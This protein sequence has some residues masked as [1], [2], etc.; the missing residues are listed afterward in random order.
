MKAK[1]YTILLFCIFVAACAQQSGTI[2]N[3]GQNASPEPGKVVEKTCTDGIKN[4]KES[5]VDCGG[6]CKKCEAGK[7]C[8]SNKDCV[9]GF[10]LN[11][12][13]AAP[14]CQD[15][16]LNQNEEGIDCGGVCNPCVSEEPEEQGYELTNEKR[17]EL[18]EKL[19]QGTKSTFL[20]RSHPSGLKVGE[21]LVYAYGMT[22]MNV[23]EDN[24]TFRYHIEFD[25]ARDT[26]NNP[27][28]V[29]EEM[30]LDWFEGNDFP[31][32]TLKTYEQVIFPVGFSVGEHIDIDKETVEGSYYF[33][34]VVEEDKGYKWDEYTTEEFSF[35]V[36]D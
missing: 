14:S 13:C 18:E 26:M 35:R 8:S 29:N 19:T 21:R 5:D 30:V 15:G 36:K 25:R 4:Q 17:E 32:P 16:I 2:E 27:I 20:V 1:I 3:S 23:N 12:V 24:T 34:L 31:E 9:T 6:E 11:G 10:C 22:N 33:E 7:N 28:P